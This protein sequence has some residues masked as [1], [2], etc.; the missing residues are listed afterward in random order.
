MVFRKLLVSDTL[1]LS[2][3]EGVDILLVQ[4]IKNMQD[5][6]SQGITRDNFGTSFFEK[7]TTISSDEQIVSLETHGCDRDVTFD[8]RLEY[9]DAVIQYRLHE[10]D[11]QAKAVQQGLSSI[12]PFHFIV[13][14]ILLLCPLNISLYYLYIVIID[15]GSIGTLCV[16]S[17]RVQLVLTTTQ[18]RIFRLSQHRCSHCFILASVDRLFE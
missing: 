8:N 3:L 2:D 13:S 18:Y 11:K 14:F 15:L 10:F 5:I 16:W 7:F 6:E 4:S 17:T 1:L 12:V 9:C